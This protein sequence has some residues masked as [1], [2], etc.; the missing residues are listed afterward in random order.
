MGT[1]PISAGDLN[2][3]V[4]PV[5]PTLKP[6]TDV[7]PRT[8]INLVNTPGDGDS[9]YR[10][11]APGSFY[12]TG[13]V[14]GAASKAGIEIAASNVSV[15][16][17]GFELQGV[18]GSLQGI[19]ITAVNAVNISIRNGAIRGWG[20][21]GV[22]TISA[23]TKVLSLLRVSTCGTN[24]VAAGAGAVITDCV[25]TANT[26]AGFTLGVGGVMANCF[27]ANNM[28]FGIS[29][30]TGNTLTNCMVI[31]NTTDGISVGQ[32]STVTSCTSR[33]NSGNGIVGGA[34]CTI[35]QCTSSANLGDG[36]LVSVDAR[37]MNNLC[38][39]QTSG[40]GIHATSDDNRI[41]SNHVTDNLRGIDVDAGGNLII[42]NSAGGNTTDYDVAAGN[43]KA[44]VLTPGDD[45][46][47]TNPW[48]NFSF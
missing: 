10:I 45:F 41:D 3:P 42:R 9:L 15:D 29:A 20:G 4:G 48:A 7:E 2:P 26:G 12:L 33:S 11:S 34:A 30:N 47:A 36:I 28:T 21:A 22:D 14:S 46:S 19:R 25:S 38:D 1:Q 13:N 37:V 35:Q 24:G 17:M 8:A 6:L 23:T 39:G 31:F 43:S 5:A 27:A 32:G 18:T 16:L 40:A 44:E